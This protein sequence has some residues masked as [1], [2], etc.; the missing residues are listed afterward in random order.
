MTNLWTQ[1]FF[2]FTIFMILFYSLDGFLDSGILTFPFV[3]LVHL[4][5]F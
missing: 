3:L 1:F 4:I 2:Q 5:R